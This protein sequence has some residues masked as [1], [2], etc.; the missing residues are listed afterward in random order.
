MLLVGPPMPDRSRVM[1][2][3]K[4]IPWPSRLG[5]LGVWLTTPAFKKILLPNLKRRLRPTQGCRVDD[6]D[7]DDDD[8]DNEY[9]VYTVYYVTSPA[10][11]GAAPCN[12]TRYYV[13]L[14]RNV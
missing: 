10:Q 14:Q 6:N 4:R 2:Q 1:T 12:Q 5:G 3:T 7:N 8:N 9:V 13:F 11:S